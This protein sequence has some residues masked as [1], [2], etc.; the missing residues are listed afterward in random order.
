MMVISS[1]QRQLPAAI[2]VAGELNLSPKLTSELRRC[3]CSLFTLSRCRRR[4]FGSSQSCRLRIRL[5][6]S[7]GRT[8]GFVDQQRWIQCLVNPYRQRFTCLTFHIEDT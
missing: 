5:V 7:A 8:A 3:Y 1:S 6:V 2:A 4:A